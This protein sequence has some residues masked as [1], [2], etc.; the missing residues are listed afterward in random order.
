MNRFFPERFQLGDPAAGVASVALLMVPVVH[1]PVGDY[2]YCVYRST[3]PY[4]IK[5]R[6]AQVTRT[7]R[8]DIEP[9]E[10]PRIG[11]GPMSKL[12]LAH[13]VVE[14]TLENEAV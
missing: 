4:D 13:Q 12:D 8:D 1:V 10:V 14:Q 3:L 11:N 7:H 5:S 6:I 9:G 2:R